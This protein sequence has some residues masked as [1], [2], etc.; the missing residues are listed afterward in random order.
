MPTWQS[1]ARLRQQA[2]LVAQLAQPQLRLVQQVRRA[3]ED[4]QV[5]RPPRTARVACKAGLVEV[6]HAIARAGLQRLQLP[7]QRRILRSRG[8]GLAFCWVCSASALQ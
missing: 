6:H 7:Q 3:Q 4:E 8:V 1:V 2:E 5:V